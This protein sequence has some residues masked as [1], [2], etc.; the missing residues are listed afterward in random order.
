[1]PFLFWSGG[2]LFLKGCN[3]HV[4]QVESLWEDI[5]ALFS[6]GTSQHFTLSADCTWVPQLPATEEGTFQRVAQSQTLMQ[7][8]VLA[9]SPLTAVGLKGN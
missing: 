7:A 6:W 4:R 5:I 3:I 1:M 2:V 9:C 8:L